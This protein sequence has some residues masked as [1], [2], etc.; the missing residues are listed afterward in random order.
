MIPR[1]IEGIRSRGITGSLLMQLGSGVASTR[2]GWVGGVGRFPTAVS[3]PPLV[4]NWWHP[5]LRSAGLGLG[6]G[7]LDPGGAERDPGAVGHGPGL[8]DQTGHLH[9]GALADGL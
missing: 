8:G 9:R 6:D 4:G 2:P 1:L 5:S 7:R 3:A